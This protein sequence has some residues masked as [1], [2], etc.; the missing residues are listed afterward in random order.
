MLHRALLSDTFFQEDN[1]DAMCMHGGYS[2]SSLTA[3]AD[4]NNESESTMRGIK[5]SA[6]MERGSAIK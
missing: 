1:G 6:L 2:N 4:R 5:L 3:Y